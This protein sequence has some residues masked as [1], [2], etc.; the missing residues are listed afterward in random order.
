M[1]FMKVKGKHEEKLRSCICRNCHKHLL[2]Y[3]LNY[4]LR[5]LS[6]TSQNLY[7]IQISK[8][9]TRIYSLSSSSFHKNIHC[10][11]KGELRKRQSCKMKFYTHNSIV[12]IYKNAKHMFTSGILIAYSTN[13]S[14]LL[15]CCCIPTEAT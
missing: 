13:L 4:R 9:D 6:L 11:L 3:F 15:F 14:Q 1:Q 10:S 5:I 7:C 2:K 12:L 8:Y